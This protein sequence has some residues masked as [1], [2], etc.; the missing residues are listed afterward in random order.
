MKLSEAIR[1]GAKLRQQAFGKYF[2][3]KSSCAV[4]A[5]LEG[6]LQKEKRLETAQEYYSKFFI[7]T[8]LAEIYP[9]FRTEVIDPVEKRKGRLEEVIQTLNDTHEWS[10]NQIADWLEKEG[11]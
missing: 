7:S 8:F 9:Y 1:E 10:R 5:A 11:Y 2:N 4:G 3:E 6:S